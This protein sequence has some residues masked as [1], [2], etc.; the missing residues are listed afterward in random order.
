MKIVQINSV[1]ESGSTGKICSE[2]SKLLTEKGI[3][4][5]ILYA[6]GNSKS[7]NAIKYMSEKEVKLQALKS[8]ISGKYGFCTKQSTNRLISKLEEISPDIVH[9]HNLHSHNV[10]L[11][12]L[13]EY[14]KR[15]RIKIIWT[16]HDCWAFTGYCTYYDLVQCGQWKKECKKCPVKNHY[17]L[18]FDRSN[19]LFKNKKRLFSDLDLTIVTPSKW[20]AAQVKQSF[21]GNYPVKVIYNGIDC[22]VFKPV[23]SDFK[24][25]YN[26]EARFIVLGVAYKWEKRKGLDVFL[27]LSKRLDCEKYKIVLIGTD[28]DVDK[29]LPSNILGIHRTENQHELAG[30]YTAADVFVNPTR[31][32]TL[33]LVNLEAN[34]CGTPVITFNTGGSPECINAES[35]VVVEKDD[36]DEMEKQIIRISAQKPFDAQSCI[37]RAAGFSKSEKY[38]EYLDLYFN[39]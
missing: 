19:Y 31:E 13:F 2:I 3:E 5:Y 28:N 29:R 1:Y 36:V 17:S 7:P 26:Q 14:L 10:N 16:F 35:G 30:I 32:E 6:I 21:F 8:K 11:E 39:I 37:D 12:L 33:G 23:E 38:K 4:N 24:E 20:L 22:S 18:F 25:K 15:K 9:L 34:A 27:E